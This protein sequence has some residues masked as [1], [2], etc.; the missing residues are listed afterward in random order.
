MPEI[1]QI[2]GIFLT[3]TRVQAVPV[4]PRSKSSCALRPSC[5]PREAADAVYV[6]A[7]DETTSVDSFRGLTR[8][9]S[10]DEPIWTRCASWWPTT[11]K[12]S[13]E[14]WSS[15]SS[16][17]SGASFRGGK[18]LL[19]YGELSISRGKTHYGYKSIAEIGAG[20]PFGSSLTEVD[21]RPLR[22]CRFSSRRRTISSVNC[23]N[24]FGSG[25]LAANSQSSLHF[26]TFFSMLPLA[27]A[28]RSLRV[29]CASVILLLALPAFSGR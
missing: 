23:I 12:L 3:P 1:P 11:M 17:G 19:A 16:L 20:E 4:I 7:G 2:T 26:S 14:D 8:Y 9:R 18:F 5:K 21:A 15:F 29:A 22:G 10:A 13:V 24:R 27:A 25:S 28:H 6:W